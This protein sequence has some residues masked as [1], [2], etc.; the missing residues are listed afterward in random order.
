MRRLSPAKDQRNIL[1]LEV[2]GPVDLYTQAN[3]SSGSRSDFGRHVV[4][5]GKERARESLNEVVVSLLKAALAEKD[6]PFLL[7]LRNWL[8]SCNSRRQTER[9]PR[10]GRNE[11]FLTNL[12][13]SE[14]Y[15]WSARC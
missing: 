4:R 11:Y 10:G 12:I 8:T 9:P 15:F 5:D 2:R 3:S 13:G 6:Y 7:D 1:G 14:S